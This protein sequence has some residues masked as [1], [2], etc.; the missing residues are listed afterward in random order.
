MELQ[1][2]RERFEANAIDIVAISYDSAT[3]QREAAEKLGL[4][5]PLLSDADSRVIDAFG[6]R[7]TEARGRS[8]GIPHPAIFILDET[9]V[10]RAKLAERDFKRRPSSDQIITAVKA[11]R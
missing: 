4:S 7:N 8:D 11:L 5:Y 1:D 6:V 3:K 2:N 10:I 9:G